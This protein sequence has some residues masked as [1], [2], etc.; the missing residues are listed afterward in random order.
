MPGREC[1]GGIL[2]WRW[3]ICWM[4][5]AAGAHHATGR[6][7]RR[8]APRGVFH[9]LEKMGG[10]F[11]KPWMEKINRQSAKCAKAGIRGDWAVFRL[12]QILGIAQAP[13]ES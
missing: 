9:G 11:S 12:G 6:S 13:R 1:F 7:R 10:S 4:V 2:G 8:N 3:G 5:G